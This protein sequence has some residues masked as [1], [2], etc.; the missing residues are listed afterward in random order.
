MNERIK[1]LTDAAQTA[2]MMI[3]V[4]SRKEESFVKDFEANPSHA[5]HWSSNVFTNAALKHV[6]THISEWIEAAITSDKETTLDDV[7]DRI[8]LTALRKAGDGSRSTSP[9]ANH[10]DR[11]EIEMWAK[12]A[13]RFRKDDF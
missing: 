1:K 6:W 4:A 9:S 8:V 5:L 3:E 7:I 10:I 12:A 13:L 11:E 2:A